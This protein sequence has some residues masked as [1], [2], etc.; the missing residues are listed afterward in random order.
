M[1]S[2]G[3]SLQLDGNRVFHNALLHVN[4]QSP[5][6][7]VQDLWTVIL[8]TWFSPDDGYML[9]FKASTIATESM[10]DSIIQVIGVVC[11]PEV[12]DSF[13]QRQVL[14]VECKR[15]SADTPKGWETAI[16]NQVP[17]DMSQ[18]WNTSERYYSAVAIGTK[19]RFFKW[20]GGA[21]DNLKLC[22]LHQ[23]TFDLGSADGCMQVE[24]MVNHVKADGLHWV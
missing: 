19:V 2:F 8:A 16:Q 5:E 10:P 24:E 22:P 17:D 23:G 18:N 20:D 15:P 13:I 9:K 12:S 7:V 3:P 4:P 6:Q 14:M 11:N 1:H 21:V